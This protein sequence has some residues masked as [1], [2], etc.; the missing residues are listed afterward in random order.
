M[1]NGEVSLLMTPRRHRGDGDDDDDVASALK[2]I[3]ELARG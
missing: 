3:K 1:V 2:D